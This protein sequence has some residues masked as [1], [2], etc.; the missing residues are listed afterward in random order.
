MH[1]TDW[2]L[3]FALVRAGNNIAAK[4]AMIAIT[5]N[6]SIKV[7]PELPDCFLRPFKPCLFVFMNLS[8]TQRLQQ[9]ILPYK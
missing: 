8:D 3:I 7:K 9:I 6:N 2:A 5:T 1:E 4:M